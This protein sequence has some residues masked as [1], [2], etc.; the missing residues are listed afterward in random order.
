MLL[1]AP[2]IAVASGVNQPT[3]HGT[4]PLDLGHLGPHEQHL[5]GAAARRGPARRPGPLVINTAVVYRTVDLRDA[6]MRIVTT[7][8]GLLPC[9]QAAS[10]ACAITPN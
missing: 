1:P 8:T 7:I 2:G 9:G 4:I 10:V 5:P 6:G 3:L